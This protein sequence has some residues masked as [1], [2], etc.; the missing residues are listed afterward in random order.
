MY[1]C[2]DRSFKKPHARSKCE[3]GSLC[4]TFSPPGIQTTAHKTTSG[5]IHPREAGIHTLLRRTSWKLDYCKFPSRVSMQREHPA[6][7]YGDG[8]NLY[9]TSVQYTEA[10]TYII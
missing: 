4:V 2:R 6:D 7:D 10:Q 8:K 5:S 9:S 3:S 1:A